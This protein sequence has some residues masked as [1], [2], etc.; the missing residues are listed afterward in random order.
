MGNRKTD[1]EL[2]QDEKAHVCEQQREQ[3]AIKLAKELERQVDLH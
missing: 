3:G 2:E 1:P